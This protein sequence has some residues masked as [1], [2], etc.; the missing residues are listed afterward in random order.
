MPL[1]QGTVDEP[2]AKQYLDKLLELAVSN[3]ITGTAQPR[4]TAGEDDEEGSDPRF[5]EA[6]EALGSGDLEAAVA[7]YEKLVSANPADSE[8]AERLAGVRLMQRTSGADLNAAREQAANNPDDI[9]AQLL[10]A[11][12]D[13]SGGHIDDAFGR[14]IDLV[15]R[16]FGDDR[17]RVRLRLIDLFTV[18]GNDDERV[19]RARRDLAAALF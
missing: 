3:G 8:A 2:T 11:D 17:E 16:T 14:L 10:V 7:A 13:V 9:D 12:L 18:V 5:A 19:G 6:D 4:Q 1:F 15:H